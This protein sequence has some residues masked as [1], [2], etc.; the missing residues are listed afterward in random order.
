[1]FSSLKKTKIADDEIRRSIKSFILGRVEETTEPPMEDLSP[2]TTPKGKKKVFIVHGR[3][4]ESAY[5]LERLL[6]KE[7]GLEGVVLQDQPHG[8]KTIIEKIEAYSNVDFAFAILTPDD[9][10]ALK[11]EKLKERARQNV[12][13]EWG[14]FAAK[15]GRNK[16]CV[17]LKGNIELPS[18]MNGIGYYRYHENVEEVYLK[19]KKE[20]KDCKILE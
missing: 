18:D 1:M 3:D 4:T 10:G 16:T 19:I 11:G 15:I 20:L 17:L 12:V 6:D 13:L 8:G 7:L 9:E 14:L 5:A 2:K